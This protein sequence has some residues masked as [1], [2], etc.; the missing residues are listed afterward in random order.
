[1]IASK[2]EFRLV[3]L[4]VG[5]GLSVFV[6][7]GNSSLLYDTGDASPFGFSQAEHVVLPFLRHKRVDTIDILVL[8]H[9]DRDHVGG[10]DD[11]REELSVRRVYVHYGSPCRPGQKLWLGDSTEITFLN[12]NLGDSERGYPAAPAPQ[13]S[14]NDG[15]CVVLIQH[16]GRRF[17]LT[18]DIEGSREQAMVR[19]WQNTLRVDVLIAAHHGSQTSS[20]LTFLK[21]ARP[22]F[23]AFSAGRGNRFGHPSTIVMDRFAARGT[24]VSSTAVDGA[25]SYSVNDHGN[26]TVE[27]MRDGTIPYWLQLP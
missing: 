11:I 25:I 9:G 5:Q 20:T 13:E 1:M 4:D 21:W 19:Y 17:L 14:D 6:K 24:K 22:D 15:S 12:G 7:S 3:V 2:A 16:G 27:G 10:L 18:G 8:S 26:I 23:V